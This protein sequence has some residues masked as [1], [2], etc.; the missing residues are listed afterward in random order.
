[1]I[2]QN[3]YQSQGTTTSISN[4]EVDEAFQERV[5]E[6]QR[7]RQR[8]IYQS[9]GYYK[10]DDLTDER[11]YNI[12]SNLLVQ[13]AKNVLAKNNGGEF[14]IDDSNKKVLR[15]LLYYFNNC[16]KALEVF[17]ERKHS[18]NKSILLCGDVGVGKTLIMDA[19]ALYLKETNNPKA[20]YNLSQTQMMNYYTTHNT[21]DKFT[22]NEE[23]SKNFEGNPVNLCINDLGLATKKF[24]G[25]DLKVIIDEFLYARYEI[26]ASQGK[27]AHITTNLD[28]DRIIDLFKD[29]S[30]RLAD[31]FKMY[32][33]VPMKGESKR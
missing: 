2:S 4:D 7:F 30:G 15:F 10:Y 12:H 16:P 19:F 11:M 6:L 33:V 22:F 8:L 28:K 23:N 25:N 24:Y 5:Q 29:D 13:C 18:L 20:F 27:C 3:F 21:L 17:P 31:R 9:K 26:W 1:M 32:N 14:I